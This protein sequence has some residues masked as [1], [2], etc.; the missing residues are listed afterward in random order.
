[1]NTKFL[2][3]VAAA[4]KI[5]LYQKL[6]IRSNYPSKNKIDGKEIYFKFEIITDH[7]NTDRRNTVPVPAT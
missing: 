5:L 3:F 4:M 1:M 2:K 7:Q 6:P